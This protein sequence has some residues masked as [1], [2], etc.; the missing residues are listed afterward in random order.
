MNSIFYLILVTYLTRTDCARILAIFPT[1][2]ISHQVVF[3]PLTQALAN[4]GHEVT[5]ITP[6]PAFKD[7]AP[8]NLTEI[9]VHDIS[10]DFWRKFLLKN[11]A[12]GGN[13]D[14]LNAFSILSESFSK[15]FFLQLETEDVQKIVRSKATYDLLLIEEC[16]RP[17]LVFSYIFKNVPVIRISSGGVMVSAYKS[18][19]LPNH[20]LLFASILQ[21]RFH[22]LTIWEKIQAFIHNAGLEYIY[23]THQIE[24]DK[25]L[26]RIIGPDVL[27]LHKLMENIDLVFYNNFPIWA[28]NIPVPPNVV[29][30]GGIYEKPK[31]EIPE[32]LKI[33]LDSSKHGVIYVSFGTNTKSSLFP[34]SQVHIFTKVFSKLPYDVLWR[35][36]EDISGKSK[37]IRITKW[38]PQPDLLRLPMFAD[39]WYNVEKYKYFGIGTKLDMNSFNEQDLRS[40]I[41]EVIENRSYRDNIVKLRHIIN[42]EP[43]KGLD[44]AIWWTEYV[45]RHGGAKHLRSPAANMSWMEYY[46]VKL[47]LTVIS[48]ILVLVTLI[49]YSI[50]TIYKYIVKMT[51]LSR[52]DC[53]RILAIFPTPSISHQVVFRPLTQ[54]LAKR[55][56]E[57]ETEDVQKIVRSKANYDLLLI[58]ECVRPALVFSYIFKNVPVIRISSGGVMVSAY[59]STGLPNHPLLFANVFQRR[60]NNLTVWEKIQAFI[61]NAGLEYIYSTHEIEDDIQLKRIIGPDVPPLQ[62]LMENIDLVF[63][64]NFHIWTANIPVPPNVMYIGGIYKKPKQEIPEDLKIFLDSSKHGVIYVRF[65][66][67]TKS[68]LFP[69]S[70]VDIFTKVFSELPYDVLWRW[71]EDSTEEA[72][73]GG[74]PLIG[75]PMFADQ[76][77]NVEKYKYFG[78]GIKLDINSFNEQD[79]RSAISE[80]I[81]NRSYRD[82][83]VKLRQILSDEPQKGLDKAIWW[84][85]YVLRHGGAKH[86]RS[87]AA[88]M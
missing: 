5:V 31:Q 61:H 43:Q 67:N 21:R 28:G 23:A 44:K 2:S 30:I 14:I 11:A 75:L 51:L 77:Y 1:P 83:I 45:L 53:A 76:W 33:F 7:N 57:L 8:R 52:T 20:P 9:D 29:Y 62:K 69:K 16:V 18:T 3:R 66:T 6:D 25:Q 71:D 64:N 50:I 87:P 22:N 60:L 46:E 15:T 81:E 35:W 58:E 85:E 38:V 73:I 26:K 80:V 63:Y 10:Y 88:N 56:H 42:D 32:D 34:K 70:Q 12:V 78:I 19:G 48:I 17:A 72:I 47:I 13:T 82:N 24:E 55:G 68:S 65:G 59:Q 4:R 79:L 41:S 86:L 54:A 49:M 40:A 36:D 74:V 27:P 84:T 39:Q 37:N